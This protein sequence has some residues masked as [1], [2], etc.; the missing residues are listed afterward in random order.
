MEAII[1]LFKNGEGA[2]TALSAYDAFLRIVLPI[3]A[4]VLI[5]RSAKSLL[6]FRKEPEVWA[7]L[8]LESG[9]L[10]PV[11]HWENVIGRKKTSDI[12]VDFATVSKS[13]AV[14]TKL[15]D[16]GW[17]IRD[18][19]ARGRVQVN[20]ETMESS[21]VTYGDVISLGGLQMTL[22]PI[23]EEE[24]QML[25]QTRTRAGKNHSPGLTL[26]LLTLFQLLTALALFIHVEQEDIFAVLM[27]FGALVVLEWLLFI[28]QKVIKRSGFELETIA[29]FLCTLG[30]SVVISKYPSTVDKVILTLAAGIV[31]FLIVGWILRDLERAKRFRYVAAVGGILLLLVNLVLGTVTNGA[32]NWIYLGGFS[33]QP[34][35]L[36]KVCFIFVGASTLD[37]LV[38]RRNLVLFIIYSAF[39][40]LCLAIMSDFGT[41][42]VF[43]VTFLA[44][45][46]LRSGSFASITLLC[47][48]L[49]VVALALL[50][51]LLL[52]RVFGVSFI[53]DKINYIFNR[54][55]TW[56]H[57][58]EGD[59]PTGYGFQQTR[60]LM[61]IASGGLFGL[62]AGNGW[63]K[64]V[65]ASETDLVFA[66]ICEELGLFMG[67]M[68]IFALAVLVLFVVRSSEV[69]RSSFYTISAS[70]AVTILTVQ[71][72]LN[73]FGTV[74]FLPLTGVTFPFVSDGGS[75]MICCWGLLA[76]V[77]AADTRQNASF[78]V[79]LADRRRKGEKE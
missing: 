38:T 40:C 76:F 5:L 20:G 17:L 14:L 49:L 22:E 70:A 23:S 77:K 2:L 65:A 33:F 55:S 13:H 72:I 24:K 37:R 57:I 32:Q 67:L 62:G 56:G 31:L 75:S 16:G 71:A 54:F 69:G 9:D 30:M 18:I 6:G 41:A 74:D 50:S 60:S 58:W 10:L 27:G 48:V 21:E 44:I 39:I 19:G 73:V 78:A 43:F 46:N 8:R 28:G 35:E 1:N 64:Y 79:T 59:N 36:V 11:T 51:A 29:F 68:M 25:T 34:S 3:L 45:A 53:I 15:E 7:W 61:C 47:S 12:V 52:D 26:V 42:L 63:L 66:F 4:F